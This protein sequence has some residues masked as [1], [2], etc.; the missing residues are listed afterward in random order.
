MRTMRRIFRTRIVRRLGAEQLLDSMSKVLAAPLE[1]EDYPDAQRLAQVPEGRKHY[2]PIKTDLD[3]FALVFGKPPRLL[4]SECERTN[5]PTVG[6]AFQLISGPVMQNLLA[7]MGTRLD[8]WLR[9]GKPARE[10]AEEMFWTAL[11]RPPTVVELERS[12]EH[13]ATARDQRR[14]AED[15]MWALFNSKE[16]LFRQ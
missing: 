14:A 16:F 6:Q 10:V 3:R 5:E 15:V 7:R 1:L 2:H 13:L 8:G 4:A 9:S 12:E 11:S